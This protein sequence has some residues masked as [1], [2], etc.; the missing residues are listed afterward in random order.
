M[1]VG[2]QGVERELGPQLRAVGCVTLAEHVIGVV[3]SRIAVVAEISHDETA[4]GQAQHRRL[5]LAGGGGRVHLEFA[6][7][8]GAVGVVTLRIDTNTAAVTEIGT[9]G[10]D[11]APVGQAG[12][13][14]F[15]LVGQRLRVDVELRP[16]SRAVR[17]VALGKHP[18][19]VTVLAVPGHPG[20]DIATVV[21]AEQ[22]AHRRRLLIARL[23]GVG[24]LLGKQRHGRSGQGLRCDVDL[25]IAHGAVHIRAVVQIDADRAALVGARCGA[26]I[27]QVLEHAFDGLIG[28]A[29]VE[30]D[31]EAAAVAAVQ[32]GADAADGYALVIDGASG[33][34]HLPGRRALVADRELV[35]GTAG[36]ADVRH[37]QFAGVEGA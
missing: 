13:A 26:A 2:H 23:K 30:G 33:D 29:G 7:C 12:N 4:I 34:P 35:F 19:A 9:P 25:H 24:L 16:G 15:V 31:F 20:D 18:V 36:R 21:R 22:A 14:R 17:V 5:E 3:R 28:S 8:S 37:Q 6:A 27:G 1:L 32:R 10:D 11:V